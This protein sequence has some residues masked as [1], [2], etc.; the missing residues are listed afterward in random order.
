[1]NTTQES[2]SARAIVQWNPLKMK[3]VEEAKRKYQE[4]RRTGRKILSHTGIAIENFSPLLGEFTIAEN[5]VGEGEIAVRLLN[6]TGD[7]RLI[8]NVRDQK[9][10]KEACDRFNSYIQRGWKAYAI[11]PDGSRGPRIYSFDANKEEVVLDDK[12]GVMEKLKNFSQS[13]KKIEMLPKTM[14]G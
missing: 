9:Q 12:R 4:A 3:E 6:E 8:W 2:Q 10:I 13:F 1:M 7:E 5:E 11:K 14:P